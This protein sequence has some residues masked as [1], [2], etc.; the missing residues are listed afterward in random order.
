MG[1]ILHRGGGMVVAME[2]NQRDGPRDQRLP[3]EFLLFSSVGV[4]GSTVV[5]PGEPKDTASCPSWR[6]NSP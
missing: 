3:R 2:T 4:G 6:R 5:D 1:S